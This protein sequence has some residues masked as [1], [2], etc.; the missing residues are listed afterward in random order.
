M[1]LLLMTCWYARS[2]EISVCTFISGDCRFLEIPIL[3]SANFHHS[4]MVSEIVEI[5]QP[6]PSGFF[7]DA[8]LGD[9]GHAEAILS[10]RSDLQLV[11]IDR[12]AKALGRARQRLAPLANN[13]KF[14]H[15]RFEALDQELE[16]SGVESLSGA[17]FD[18]GASRQQLE[19][20]DR[21]F[22]FKREGRLDMRMDESQALT[23]EEILNEWPEEK[24]A[25]LLKTYSQERYSR[26]IA[27]AIVLARPISGTHEL[28][29]IIASAIPR[30]LQ[31]R[32]KH[33]A[34]RSFMAL[35]IAVNEELDAIEEALG[36]AINYLKPK[37][38]C[39]VLSY[40]S[41]E[42]RIVKHFLRK[43]A[44]AQNP[45]IRLLRRKA[46]FPSPEEIKTNPSSRSARL[47]ACERTKK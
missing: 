31:K 40:H 14:I 45:K 22:G 38:R 41:G 34:R 32:S 15:N 33:P 18:L 43:E 1:P 8:T 27:K 30:P 2:K 36:K 19:D 44:D 17:L 5:F 6:I 13:C 12:D 46:T 7:L 24:I 23:A 4:V 47:R 3:M 42:D 20:P 11:G 35:R 26:A 10:S 9:G 21:G 29:K 39:T 37:G 28:A 25:V 16:S